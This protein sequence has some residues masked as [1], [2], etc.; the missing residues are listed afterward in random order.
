VATVKTVLEAH[1]GRTLIHAELWRFFA[2]FVI[3]HYDFQ[4]GA[5]SRDEANT[6]ERLKG[7]LP[8]PSSMQPPMPHF[9]GVSVRF[10]VSE[11]IRVCLLMSANVGS[12]S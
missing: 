12:E 9:I 5:G 7:L 10:S 3:V 8:L 4:S 6:I 11:L 1:A 2:V